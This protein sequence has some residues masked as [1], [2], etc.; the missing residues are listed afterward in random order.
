MKH[1]RRA[2]TT[3]RWLLGAL[4]V[5]VT[6]VALTVT[7]AMGSDSDPGG[8]VTTAAPGLDVIQKFQDCMSEH[9][10][11]VPEPGEPFGGPRKVHEPSAKERE[12]LEAC[13]DVMPARPPGPPPMIGLAAGDRKAFTEFRDCMADHGVDLPAPSAGPPPRDPSAKDRD[14][15]EA[16]ADQLPKPPAGGCP[17]PGGPPA[18]EMHRDD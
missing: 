10:V 14:A 2:A 3:S 9:G 13:Q 12:A 15:F 4:A 5:A 17:A 8:D 6:A 11:D 7:N 1:L 16:C 18:F